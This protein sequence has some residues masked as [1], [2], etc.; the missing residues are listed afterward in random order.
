M[1][2]GIYR[3]VAGSVAQVRQLDVLANNLAHVDTP[4]F[5]ADALRFE[6]MLNRAQQGT[7]FVDT[8]ETTIQMTQGSL[9]KTDNPLD[10]AVAGDGFLVVDTPKGSRL[11]RAGRMVVGADGILRTVAGHPVQGANGTISMVPLG[12]ERREGPLVIES[13]GRIMQGDVELGVLR[14]VAA[15]ADELKKEGLDMFA[16]KAGDVNNLPPAQTGEILQGHVEDA[17]V[18]PVF[19]MTEIIQVQRTFEALQQMTKTYRD[20]DRQSVRRMR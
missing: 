6:E 17:N 7:G 4:G 10:V 15:G 2:N 16:L 12:D 14:R 13:N 3:A 9:R 1:A 8:G 20:T 5:K 18:N 11:T 19:A